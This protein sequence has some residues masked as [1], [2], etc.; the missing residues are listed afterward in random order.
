MKMLVDRNMWKLYRGCNKREHNRGKTVS[1]GIMKRI[2]EAKKAAMRLPL[3]ESGLLLTAALGIYCTDL[4]SS[5]HV[6]HINDT[7]WSCAVWWL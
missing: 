7:C 3:A 1:E 5:H 6:D 4:G 2:V